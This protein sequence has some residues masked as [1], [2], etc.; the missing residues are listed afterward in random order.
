MATPEKLVVGIIVLASGTILRLRQGLANADIG[1]TASNVISFLLYGVLADAAAVFPAVENGIMG[2]DS[3]L[4]G[5]LSALGSAGNP[6]GRLRGHVM[7]LRHSSVGS[8]AD[9]I[10]RLF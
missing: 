8:E 1:Q 9:D 3:I 10:Q 7:V 6:L 4:L 2:G 5:R